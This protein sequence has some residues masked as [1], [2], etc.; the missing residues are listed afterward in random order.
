M[1]IS[2]NESRST[3]LLRFIFGMYALLEAAKQTATDA[4]NYTAS[5]QIQHLKTEI[6]DS[7]KIIYY[8]FA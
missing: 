1:G 6:G 8:G 7:M 3:K 2:S 5:S 4:C